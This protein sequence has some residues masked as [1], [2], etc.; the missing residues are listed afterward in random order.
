METEK[1]TGGEVNHWDDW[2]PAPKGWICPCCGRVNA[3][4]VAHCDCTGW[5]YQP[6][7]PYYPNTN[8]YPTVTWQVICGSV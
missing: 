7:Y 3:P 2:R 4:W 5:Y 1:T 8:P 6:Y